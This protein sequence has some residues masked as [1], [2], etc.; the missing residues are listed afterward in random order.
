MKFKELSDIFNSIFPDVTLQNEKIVSVARIPLND[1][2][3]LFHYR[4]VFDYQKGFLTEYLVLY[5]SKSLDKE[6][7]LAPK[8]FKF[9][10]NI[11]RARLLEL[12]TLM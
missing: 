8:T 10:P 1:T 3:D 12:K 4:F 6:I 2:I 9:N 5:Y 7:L 11:W